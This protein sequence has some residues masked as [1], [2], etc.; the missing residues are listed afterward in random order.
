MADRRDPAALL[1]LTPA[2][3]HVLVSLAEGGKHG[4]AIIKDVERMTDGAVSLSTGTLYNLLKRVLD[5]G[6]ATERRHLR[7]GDDP[8]RRC[9]QL[10]SLGRAVV[11]AETERLERAAALARALPGLRRRSASS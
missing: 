11:L 8:R 6:L 3:F 9:Y 4:Y 5:E 10:T 7:P 1:P 2:M